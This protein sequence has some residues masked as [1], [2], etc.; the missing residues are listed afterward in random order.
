MYTDAV[1][2]SLGAEALRE[3]PTDHS[4]KLHGGEEGSLFHRTLGE[5]PSLTPHL[6]VQ[7]QSLRPEAATTESRKGGHPPCAHW[8]RPFP[9]RVYCHWFERALTPTGFFPE[10]IALRVWVRRRIPT[11]RWWVWAGD[12]QMDGCTSRGRT[13]TTTRVLPPT[14]PLGCARRS[15]TSV[16]VSAHH[17]PSKRPWV[18]LHTVS[19][20]GRCCPA[21][22]TPVLSTRLTRNP[23][24]LN[25][26][27]SA[28]VSDGPEVALN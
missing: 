25:F 18:G 28:T 10:Y 13:G 27:D 7:P 15:W 2:N 14:A 12:T 23:F 24:N 4:A 6:P 21:R 22:V 16:W 5:R 8:R 26:F 20:Q 3:G 1:A 19:H 11:A 17:L 9:A